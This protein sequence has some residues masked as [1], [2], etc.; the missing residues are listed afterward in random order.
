MAL[1]LVQED[2]SLHKLRIVSDSMS[3][4]QF[5]KNLHLSQ[6]VAKSDENKILNALASHTKRGCHLTFTCC[7]SHSG[8]RGN[9]LAD[10]AAKQ[11]TTVE[12]EGVNHHYD[13]AK[14]GRRPRNPLLPT[15]VY[16]TPTVKEARR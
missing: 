15:S 16:V 2:V 1:K 5:I 9:E 4:L 10:M 12:Q 8:V 13:S 6:Q 3:T 14:H 11:G 7:P